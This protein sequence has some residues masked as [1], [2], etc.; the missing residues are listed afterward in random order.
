MRLALKIFVAQSLVILVVAAVAYYSISEIASLLPASRATTIRTAEALRVEVLL[1][2]SM[3]QASALEQRFVVFGDQEYAGEPTRMAQEMA[4]ALS[5]LPARLATELERARLRSA[6]QHFTEY[7]EA[8]AAGRRLRAAGDA[9]Q[10]GEVVNTR[11]VAAAGRFMADMGRLIDLTQAN[12]DYTQ[13]TA[14]SALNE[15]R[16]A[17]QRLEAGT[18]RWVVGAMALGVAAALIGAAAIAYGMT[19]SLERL[20]AAARTLGETGRFEAVPVESTDQIGDLAR[21]FNKMAEDRLELERMKEQFYATVSHELRSPLTSAREAA[22]LLKSGAHGALTD[23]QER[24]AG[25]VYNSADRLLHL[26]NDIL[27]L[28]RA[29]AGVLPLEPRTFDLERAAFQAVDE[30]RVR[31]DDAQ[32]KL[33]YDRG[34]GDLELEGDESR[35]VQALV[36]LVANAIRFT[37]PGGTVTVRLTDAGD[38]LEA[39][40]EDTGVGI[41]AAEL[42]YIFDRYRQAHGSGGGTGLGLAIVRAMVEAHGGRVGVESREGHGSRFT[43]TLPRRLAAPSGTPA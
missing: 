14:S 6:V 13:A 8:T 37:P 28:S 21:S 23:K 16:A 5:A 20:S 31:A 38:Q 26:V 7:R 22:T 19:R 15:A 25:I 41:P 32:V 18:W 40:V 9:R 17:A 3:R 4:D 35:V 11:A 29:S 42:P 1:R 30:L 24:L 36:N 2:E 27:D 10:A 12:L 39:H 34:V 33:A 43:I